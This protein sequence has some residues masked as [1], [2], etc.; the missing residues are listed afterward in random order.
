MDPQLSGVCVALVLLS[1]S[2]SSILLAERE[3]GGGA[4]TDPVLVSVTLPC[5]DAI[6]GSRSS[7][8]SGFIEA[9][10]GLVDPLVRA[11]S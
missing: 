1:T 3:G 6:S 11:L 7:T 9:L 8:G 4:T 2:L 5:V 10:I